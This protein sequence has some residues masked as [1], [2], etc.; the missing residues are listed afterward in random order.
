MVK[1]IRDSMTDDMF[2]MPINDLLGFP[3]MQ[4]AEPATASWS[5]LC[6][7][8]LVYDPPPHSLTIK[9][10]DRKWEMVSAYQKSVRRADK[11]LALKL[12][13]AMDS[14]QAEFSYWW[15]RVCTTAA[16]DIGPANPELVNFVMACATIYTPSKAKHFQYKVLCFLTERM[17]ESPKSRV[18]CSLSIIEGRIKEGV[19]FQD[20]DPDNIGA[21]I[22]ALNEC[23][24]TDSKSQWVLKNNWRGEGMLKFQLITPFL[25]EYKGSPLASATLKGL[26]SYAYDMHT[27]VGKG[28]CVR[29]TGYSN[30]KQFFQDNACT[31]KLKA[32]GYAMFYVEGGKIKDEGY[33][34]S[35]ARLEQDVV[36]R[37]FGL[38]SGAFTLLQ[39]YIF[40]LIQDGSLDKLRTKI[41]AGQSY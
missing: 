33:N 24:F 7:D 11:D 28:A 6:Q 30:I 37:G 4:W 15:R 38:S 5:K 16:E 14:W 25:M 27:R 19:P 8:L 40:E 17:C 36:A 18:W 26:P 34:Y 23:K 29:L 13:S 21:S 2:G 12:V 41:L 32:V 3:K 31:D 10:Q 1:D 9:N 22:L 39:S 20:I 35:V